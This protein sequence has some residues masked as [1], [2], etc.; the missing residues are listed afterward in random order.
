MIDKDDKVIQ[1]TI[2]A[3]DGKEHEKGILN[4]DKEKVSDDD[5]YGWYYRQIDKL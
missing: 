3:N 1:N 5:S 2:A 4:K